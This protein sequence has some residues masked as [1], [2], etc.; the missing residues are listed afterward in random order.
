MECHASRAFSAVTVN[1]KFKALAFVLGLLTAGSVLLERPAQAQTLTVLH[2]FTGGADGEYPEAGLTMDGAGNLYGTAS[3]GGPEHNGV[4]FRLSRAGSGWVLTP[5]YSFGADPDGAFPYGGVVIGPDGGLYGT[6]SHGGQHGQGTVYR[7]RPS[8][9]GCHSVSCPWEETV[10]YSF[11]GGDDG[12]T[13]GWGNLVFD[14]AGN[15]YGTTVSGGYTMNGVAFELTQS[16]GG[17]TESVLWNFIRQEGNTPTSG[18]IFDS[19]GNLYGTTSRAGP[20][21]NGVI[22]Q[23]SPFGSGWTENVLA[24]NEF[25]NSDICGGVVMDGQGNLFGAAGCGGPGGVFELT[26]SYGSWTF[27]VLHTFSIGAGPFGGPTLDATGNVYGVSYGTGLYNEGEVFKL[28]PSHGGWTYTSVSFDGS[29]GALPRGSVNLDPAGNIYG[30]TEQ[31][32]N[33]QC[34]I[35]GITGCGVIWEITP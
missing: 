20:L 12:A 26:P 15:L 33:G 19:S 29:N 9:R 21:G 32:G 24:P 8:P 25:A 17:W 3:E 16:N 23:L 7:L 18:L 10:L 30:T 14:H 1:L 13:P 34:N 2:S 4:V 22:Y 11:T 31:G 5:L 35:G 6:T 28:T 27:N